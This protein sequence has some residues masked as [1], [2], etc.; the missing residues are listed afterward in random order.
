[1]PF[2]AQVLDGFS[3]SAVPCLYNSRLE[4]MLP[5]QVLLYCT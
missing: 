3:Q 2:V 4:P 1:M 5:L